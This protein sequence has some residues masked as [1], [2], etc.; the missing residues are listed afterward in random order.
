[1]KKIKNPR[2]KC[3]NKCVPCS[4][5]EHEHSTQWSKHPLK[6][7]WYWSYSERADA[8]KFDN[9][10]SQEFTRRWMLSISKTQ[11][12]ETPIEPAAGQ[13]WFRLLMWSLRKKSASASYS[14]SFKRDDYMQSPFLYLVLKCGLWSLREI[15]AINDS[16]QEFTRRRM[17]SKSKR[18]NEGSARQTE[19]NAPTFSCGPNRSFQL[20]PEHSSNH[21]KQILFLYFVLNY[22][23]WS[24]RQMSI[25]YTRGKSWTCNLENYCAMLER[26]RSTTTELV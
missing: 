25:Y 16:S 20:I 11:P 14:K 5:H 21:C 7:S 19:N 18:T 17:V 13:H 15:P 23:L 10:S 22:G 6:R 4:Q 26:Q 12:R 1:M 3:T 24:F 9:D 8:L 2:Q